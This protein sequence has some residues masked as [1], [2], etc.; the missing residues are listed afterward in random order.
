MTLAT[1]RCSVMAMMA[2]GRRPPNVGARPSQHPGSGQTR[3]S[4]RPPTAQHLPQAAFARVQAGIGIDLLNRKRRLP[5]D[6][7]AGYLLKLLCSIGR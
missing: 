1:D 5:L 2:A 4:G 3:T 6:F 7:E